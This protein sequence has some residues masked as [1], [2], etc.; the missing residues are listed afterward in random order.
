MCGLACI[1]R[2]GLRCKTAFV[3]RAAMQACVQRVS[4]RANH[5]FHKT[6]A[7]QKVRFCMSGQT[8]YE[9]ME[10]IFQSIGA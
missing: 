1:A 8:M 2:F 7:G 9:D 4:H 10:E 6:A 3:D 5:S